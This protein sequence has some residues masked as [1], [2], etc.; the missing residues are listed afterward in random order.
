MFAATF[1]GYLF[2]VSLKEF[3]PPIVLRIF[4]KVGNYVNSGLI[5]TRSYLT[6]AGLSNDLSG[7]CLYFGNLG[8]SEKQFYIENFVGLA[9]VPKTLIIYADPAGT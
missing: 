8:P 5:Q 2:G 1:C 4:K 3:T 6:D 7:R 9:L